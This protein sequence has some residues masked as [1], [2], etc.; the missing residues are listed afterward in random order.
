[1]STKTAT[2][3]KDRLEGFRGH[4]ALYRLD[5]PIEYES[6]RHEHVVVSSVTIPDY[7][8]LGV[9]GPEAYIFPASPEGKVTG[10]GELPGSLNGTLDHAEALRDAGYEVTR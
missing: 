9:G 6:E 5:P 1:M 3:V 7:G 8:G 10:W 4:A 2:L